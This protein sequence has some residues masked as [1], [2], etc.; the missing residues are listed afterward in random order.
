VTITIPGAARF[1]L[2]VGP[3]YV[4][5]W[6][7]GELADR[8]DARHVAEEVEALLQQTGYRRLLMDNRSTK[9][10]GVAIRDFVW[11]WVT[12]DGFERVAIVVKS[13]PL[14]QR[15]AAREGAEGRVRAFTDQDAATEWIRD[16]AAANT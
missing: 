13:A 4:H 14:V 2:E 7:G 5:L 1:T 12:G 3:G 6:Q 16:G 15:I 8:D 10:P 11:R 9:A